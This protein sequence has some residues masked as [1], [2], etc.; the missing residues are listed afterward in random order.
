MT[1]RLIALVAGLVGTLALSAP[2]GASTL[3]DCI[4]RPWC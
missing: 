1:R 2:A 3:P 4:L